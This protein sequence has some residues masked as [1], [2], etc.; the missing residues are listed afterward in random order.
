MAR[1]PLTIDLGIAAALL[2]FLAIGLLAVGD[3]RNGQLG[4]VGLALLGLGLLLAVAAAATV[5]F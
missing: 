1:G 3:R 4:I 2:G 5:Q